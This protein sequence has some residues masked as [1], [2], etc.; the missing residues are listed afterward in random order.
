MNT[1]SH[2]I[3]HARER[4][5]LCALV[6]QGGRLNCAALSLLCHTKTDIVSVNLCHLLRANS[7]SIVGQVAILP[8]P[9]SVW[10]I[11]VTTVLVIVTVRMPSY[12]WSLRW[13][14]CLLVS[15]SSTLLRCRCVYEFV[16]VRE[17]GTWPT[18][19]SKISCDRDFYSLSPTCLGAAFVSNIS[20][21][22]LLSVNR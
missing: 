17:G 13:T 3:R 22:L 8:H 14:P 10:T 2:R 1:T 12:F 20:W 15:P 21:K 19:F 4:T 6:V 11:D 5:Y 18:F 9:S 16:Y 7:C